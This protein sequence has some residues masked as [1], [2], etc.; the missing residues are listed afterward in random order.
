M[1][2]C[3]E[4]GERGER[5]VG[6]SKMPT[7]REGDERSLHCGGTNE[8][9]AGGCSMMVEAGGFHILL[10]LHQ[11]CFPLSHLLM[12]LFQTKPTPPSFTRRDRQP[13]TSPL[14]DGRKREGRKD[15]TLRQA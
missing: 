9:P 7:D 12:H 15:R 14:T 13:G 1:G 4:R 3:G 11:S 2:R 8:W 10:P 5:K 6:D